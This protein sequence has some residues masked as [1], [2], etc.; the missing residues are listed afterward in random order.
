[1]QYTALG[2]FFFSYTSVVSGWKIWKQQQVISPASNQS[3]NRYYDP[4][5]CSLT[6]GSPSAV[7]AFLQWLMLSVW[8]N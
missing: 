1:M 6:A 8:R 3:A 5:M 4:S 7:M 2:M